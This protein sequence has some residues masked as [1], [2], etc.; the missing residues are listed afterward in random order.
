MASPNQRV[1]TGAGPSSGAPQRWPTE[2]DALIARMREVLVAAAD[3]VPAG[4]IWIGD[5]AAVVDPPP[6][7]LVLSTD[8]TVS[9]V[10]ADLSLAGLYDLGWKAITAAVSDLGAM[11]ATPLRAL[12]TLCLPAGVDLEA[13]VRGIA[14]ASAAWS[15]P[16]VGGDLSSASEIV[17]SV[18]VVG[19]LSGPGAPVGRGG[20][21]AGNQLFVTGPLGVSAAGLRALR[22]ACEA[23]DPVVSEHPHP[24][25][26]WPGPDGAL[27]DVHRHPK[28]RL[29]EGEVGR[30]AGATAMMD[31][32]DGLSRDLHRLAAASGVGAD[33]VSVPVASGA[34]LAEA[35][36]GGE[37]YEL[38]IATPDPDGLL[39]GFARAGLRAPPWIG[40]CTPNAGHLQLDGEPLEPTG[41]TYEL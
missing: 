41:W 36:G 16:V 12:L 15:C 34:T 13:L 40:V 30:A 20:A 28:A 8:A 31:V 14:S 33:L 37:D 22:R 9:G 27:V 17:A 7:P 35:L 19:A 5:D 26:V 29:R 38:I 23:G 4:E 32:S 2:E 3:G 21:V 25:E 24:G 39:A 1:T 11:G 6:G 10:H 18:A